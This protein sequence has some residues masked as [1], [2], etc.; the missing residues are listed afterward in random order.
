MPT[1]SGVQ[2][3]TTIT[4]KVQEGHSAC[5]FSVLVGLSVSDLLSLLCHSTIGTSV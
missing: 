1:L 4:E 2:V 3:T 5:R